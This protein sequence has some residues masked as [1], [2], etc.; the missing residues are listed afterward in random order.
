MANVKHNEDVQNLQDVRNLVI[1][2]ILRK[3]IFTKEAVV[4]TVNKYLEGSSFYNDIP[5][6]DKHV[7]DSLDFLQNRDTMRRRNGVCYMR[8]PITH[9]FDLEYYK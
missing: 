4:N 5:L 3:D 1:G 8:N 2:V 6:I 7:S 9:N